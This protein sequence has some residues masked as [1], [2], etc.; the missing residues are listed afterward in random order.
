MMS[1]VQYRNNTLRHAMETAALPA[2]LCGKNTIHAHRVIEDHLPTDKSTLN[3]P[4]LR[5]LL[6]QW[7]SLKSQPLTWLQKGKMKLPTCLV[8]E[9]SEQLG[10]PSTSASHPSNL[11][12]HQTCRF[13]HAVWQLQ[14][15]QNAA[16]PLQR[17]HQHHGQE[18]GSSQGP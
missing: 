9:E 4:Q 8:G 17:D 14:Q 1:W 10:Q 2:F 3:W 16:T 18:P 15:L 11:M 12:A 7:Q 13:Q 6:N 5:N